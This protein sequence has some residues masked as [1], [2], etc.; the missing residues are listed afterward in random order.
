MF[1]KI[2]FFILNLS[3]ICFVCH[4]KSHEV[5]AGSGRNL[6]ANPGFEEGAKGW[7]WMDWSKAWIG[8]FEISDKIA[9][10][11]KMSAYL[12]LDERIDNPKKVRGV[13][14]SLKPDKFPK[15]ASGWYR[16]E[17]W[18]RGV[19]KQYIQAVVIAWEKYDDYP[20]YQ[21]RYVLEGVARQPLP[22][23]NARYTILTKS[24]EPETGKWKY[25]ELPIRDDYRKLWKQI[26]KNYEKINFF[27]EVRYD[28]PL[29]SGGYVGADVYFD[30]LYVGE[31]K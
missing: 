31:G 22:I 29:P 8:P 30:D 15:I 27:C 28:D 6:L 23:A 14:Q 21:L 7:F 2:G 5:T 9:H 17:G 20:N 11:G 16:V 18:H 25:F 19:P 1:K 13:V 3:I 26:P 10:T 24:A 4:C 12:K